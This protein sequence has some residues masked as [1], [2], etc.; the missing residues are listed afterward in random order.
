MGDNGSIIC[1]MLNVEKYEGSPMQATL[2]MA[3]IWSQLW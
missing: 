1:D 2:L 3:A